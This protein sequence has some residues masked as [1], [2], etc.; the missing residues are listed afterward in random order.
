MGIK[1]E[2][3]IKNEEA[4]S[5]KDTHKGAH[6]NFRYFDTHGGPCQSEEDECMRTHRADGTTVTLF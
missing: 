3:L 2:A 5:F 4:S 6:K 1:M